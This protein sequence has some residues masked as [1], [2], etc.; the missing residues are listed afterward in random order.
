VPNVTEI[1]QPKPPGPHRAC[2]GTALPLPYC[3]CRGFSFKNT[4][5]SDF[6]PAVTTVCSSEVLFFYTHWLYSTDIAVGFVGLMFNRQQNELPYNKSLTVTETVF[7]KRR[8]LDSF[9]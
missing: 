6:P 7:T 2:Y 5:I 1:W 9:S 4:S 8:L 3:K